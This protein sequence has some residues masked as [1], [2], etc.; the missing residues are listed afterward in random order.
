MYFVGIYPVRSINTQI[1]QRL[2]EV[3]Q[4]FDKKQEATEALLELTIK[5]G[6]KWKNTPH[7]SY[8]INSSQLN[9]ALI[10]EVEGIYFDK[11]TEEYIVTNDVGLV[12]LILSNLHLSV[13][14]LKITHSSVDLREVVNL[15]CKYDWPILQHL[16]VHCETLDDITLLRLIKTQ[17]YH[18]LIKFTLEGGKLS[19]FMLQ[20]LFMTLP[21]GLEELAIKQLHLPHKSDSINHFLQPL[22]D[23]PRAQNLLS[24]TFDNCDLNAYDLDQL[25]LISFNRLHFLSIRGNDLVNYDLQKLKKAQWFKNLR[26]LDISYTSIEKDF[27]DF[28]KNSPITYQ[29]EKVYLESDWSLTDYMP[30]AHDERFFWGEI[31]L[32]N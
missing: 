3:Y 12:F 23:N 31:S 5:D 14:R 27:L 20:E 28:L 19:N 8:L 29:L 30:Y 10:N 32:Q 22:L 11:N 17:F 4:H 18:Q 7:F 21:S 9:S 24:L 13:R 2:I 1:T 25:L 26:E 16:Y 6:F 15:L